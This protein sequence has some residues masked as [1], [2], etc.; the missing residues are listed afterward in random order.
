M[1]MAEEGA[2][3]G[4]VAAVD[5][6]STYDRLPSLANSA[7]SVS[8]VSTPASPPTAQEL[9][10]S[11]DQVNTKLADSGHVMSLNV[12]AGTG[13]MVATIKDAQTGAVVE[14]FPGTDAIHLAQMLSGWASGKN[15]LLDLIA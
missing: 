11:L 2:S 13:L 10:S 7:A 4:S 1:A 9:Q 12:D 3:L 6:S 14:Q 15:I 5:T 8:N